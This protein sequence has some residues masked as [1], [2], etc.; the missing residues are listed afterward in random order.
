MSIQG[1][2]TYTHNTKLIGLHEDLQGQDRLKQ[3]HE[4]LLESDSGYIGDF[5]KIIHQFDDSKRRDEAHCKVAQGNLE[6]FFK[7]HGVDFR[8][9]LSQTANI[10]DKNLSTDIEKQHIVYL[11]TYAYLNLNINAEGEIVTRPNSAYDTFQN[12]AIDTLEQLERAGF[13][14]AYYAHAKLSIID[15]DKI[16]D[17]VLQGAK[18]GDLECRYA[19]VQRYLAHIAGTAGDNPPK[20]FEFHP[21][22]DEVTMLNWMKEARTSGYVVGLANMQNFYSNTM[23]A[24]GAIHQPASKG[25]TEEQKQRLL[26]MANILQQTSGDP[27]L[28]DY[29]DKI[30]KLSDGR[31]IEKNYPTINQDFLDLK[32]EAD[33]Y[34]EQHY[35]KPYEKNP[36]SI[37]KAVGDEHLE[38][39]LTHTVEEQ[40]RLYKKN[41]KQANVYTKPIANINGLRRELASCDNY[42]DIDKVLEKSDKT[43]SSLQKKANKIKDTPKSFFSVLKQIGARIKGLF[44]QKTNIQYPSTLYNLRREGLSSLRDIV[45]KGRSTNEQ[46]DNVVKNKPRR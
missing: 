29:V 35:A 2:G 39:L 15:P 8:N 7:A 28:N 13:T 23:N 17:I 18:E 6:A 44:T 33:Q 25:V 24:L 46:T 32:Q 37:H 26:E 38:N 22:V 14:H 20:T 30:L 40:A 1:T 45:K 12:Q 11:L 4:A 27:K 41:E 36:L 16:L 19:Y 31:D 3:A 5:F 34:L 43:V 21:G 9:G 42:R 10:Q